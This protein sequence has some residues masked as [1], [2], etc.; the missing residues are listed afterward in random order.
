MVSVVEMDNLEELDQHHLAWSDLLAKTP[1]ASFFQ[2]LH[3]LRA[4]WRDS[5]GDRK[6]RILAVRSRGELIG[7]LPLAVFQQWRPLGRSRVLAYSNHDRRLPG[8]PIGPQPAATLCAALRYLHDRPGGS[9]SLQLYGGAEERLKTALQVTGFRFRKRRV[10]G[11]GRID[12]GGAEGNQETR[13][14]WS[15]ST[16]PTGLAAS[17]DEAT[18][19]RCRPL[20]AASGDDNPHWDVFA[21]CMAPGMA[22]CSTAAAD[23]VPIWHVHQNVAKSGGLDLNLLRLRGEIVAYCYS[24]HFQGR[25]DCWRCGVVQRYAGAERLLAARMIEDSRQRGDSAIYFHAGMASL[26]APWATPALR[27]Q[28]MITARAPRG[29]GYRR[30]GAAAT[31]TALPFAADA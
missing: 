3:W 15:W 13:A 7:I 29:A 11:S 16:R 25:V 23:G 27:P 20:G 12:L 30:G 21:D 4:N 22:S 28:H 8:G 6:L 26:F 17:L 14:T 10:K 2:S 19:E 9:S 18:Y 31:I 1:G 5:S 24:V